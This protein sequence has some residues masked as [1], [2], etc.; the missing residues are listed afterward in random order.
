MKL[1]IKNDELQMDITGDKPDFSKYTTQII[2]LANQN[3]QATRPNVVGQMSDLI[4]EF[5][6]RTFHEWKEWYLKRYCH[7]V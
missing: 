2:N 1:K 7:R 5:P 6:G 3:A 4:Q